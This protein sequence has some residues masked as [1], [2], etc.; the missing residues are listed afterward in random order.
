M[1]LL[2]VLGRVFSSAAANVFQKQFTHKGLHSLFIVM[3]S[4]LVL[5]CISLPLLILVE[6]NAIDHSFWINILLAA[7]LDMAGTLFLVLSLSKTDLSVFGPLNAYKV[8]IS[9]ILALIFLGEVPSF[10]G[11]SGVIIILL[12]SFFVI[13][14]RYNS[15][16]KPT[17]AIIHATR[18]A[19][20]F[21][22]HIVIFH[23]HL[24]A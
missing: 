7:L 16:C 11:L 4:Y 5:A 19:I 8:V 13:P 15:I 18:R 17:V 1:E 10:Q 14:T 24:A 21:F 6:Y 23:W 20:S 12:G 2:I 9:M 3:L 22:I